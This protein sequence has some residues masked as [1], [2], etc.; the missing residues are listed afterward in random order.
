MNKRG[1]I[2]R[3]M[4]IVGPIT[5]PKGTREIAWESPVPIEPSLGE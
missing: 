4:L 3:L 1:A 2:Y 5:S